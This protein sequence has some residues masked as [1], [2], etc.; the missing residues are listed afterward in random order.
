MTLLE[1]H[2]GPKAC[3]ERTCHAAALYRITVGTQEPNDLCEFH[4]KEEYEGRFFSGTVETID[5]ENN[6]TQPNQKATK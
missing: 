5:L 1:Q 4:Y 3:E 2:P 6:A